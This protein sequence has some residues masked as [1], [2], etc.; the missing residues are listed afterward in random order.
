MCGIAGIVAL[1]GR[2]VPAALV[3]RMAATLEHRGPDDGGG[4]VR[5]ACGFGHCRL[6]I[7]DLSPSARQPLTDE[8]GNVWLICNGEIYNHEALREQLLEAGHRFRSHSDSEVL[9]H[10]VEAHP[11]A[12]ERVL[13]DL[14]GMF[15]FAAWD[16][17]RQRLLLARDRLGIKPL[18][19]A[20]SGPWLLFGSEPKAIL[21]SGLVEAR[22]DMAAVSSY[23]AYRHAIAPR[24]MFEGIHALEPGHYLVAADG[25]V[26]VRRYWDIPA[27]DGRDLGEDYYVEE[28]R[29][30]LGEAVRKRLMS[31]VPIGAYLS[32]G[33]DSSI[34]V[35][36]MAQQSQAPVKTYSVGFG[37]EGLD[38][39]PFARLV[40]D[41]YATDHHEVRLD[42][43]GYFDLLPA[44]IRQRDAPLGVP[45][46]VPLYQMSRALKQ[47]F[48]VVLSG[49]G[50][51]ELFAGYGDYV[52]TPFDWRKG[53][54]L[55]RLPPAALGLLGGGIEQKYGAAVSDPDQVTHFLAGYGWFRPAEIASLLTPAA[56]A[57]AGAGGRD[58]VRRHFDATEG[59]AP[60]DR[61]LYVLEKVHLV[62]LL[63]RVDAMTMATAVEARVPFVDH[64]LVEFAMG[65]PL[66]YKLRWR[67]PFHLARASLSYSD[68]FR[69]RDDITK[70]VL[71]RAFEDQ[72]PPDVVR[73]SKVGF[74]VPLEQAFRGQLMALGR[75]LLL[76][77]A[78]RRHGILDVDAVARW[79]DAGAQNGG[80]FGHRVWMLV[81]LELWCRIY[82]DGED[83]EHTGLGALGAA[84]G[85]AR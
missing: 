73:R 29:R 5:G 10:L 42:A 70:W 48:T 41:R 34:V 37:E 32:G 28:T 58:E 66:R 71:R 64:R 57:A 19:W 61:V 72:L 21:A 84:P 23:L 56:A 27:P 74:K 20:R 30:L 60:Y 38:E 39:F 68:R 50:A 24:T 59:W 80:E 63:A 54:V 85:T 46:E 14:D 9:A 7:I 16:A 69:E 55:G 62:N 18:Y 2:E 33:L 35:A 25:E 44:L 76:S 45:N 40:A 43:P 82:L 78:A 83:P 11:E 53:R 75:S 52:R 12:P 36:L 79:L 65:M 1:D 49:E 13:E 81:N 47:D 26:R 4:L 51:D 8:S 67:S 15:A 6:S 17:E 3:A 77:E 22:P 31:D